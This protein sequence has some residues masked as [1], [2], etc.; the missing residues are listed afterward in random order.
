[1]KLLIYFVALT[2]PMSGVMST[3][4]QSSIHN[5]ETAQVKEQDTARDLTAAKKEY[6]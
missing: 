2:I 3:G 4:Y 5:I 6:I 1:M